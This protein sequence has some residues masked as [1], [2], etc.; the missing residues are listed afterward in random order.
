V[1]LNVLAYGFIKSV[2]AF[3]VAWLI[4]YLLDLDLGS[5]A[6]L[7]TI[8]WSASVF[9][10]G[11]ASAVFNRNYDKAV[12]VLQLIV[13]FFCFIFLE[14]FHSKIYET[15]IVMLIITCGFFYGGPY[16]LMSTAIPILLG[17]QPAVQQYANGKG[18]IIALMEGYGQLFCGISLLLVPLFKVANLNAAGAA[19][20]LAALLLLAA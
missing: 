10:G 2:N 5:E 20:C 3:I 13:S 9:A 18:M 16:N 17:S 4:Y 8:L 7:M 11:M 6:V 14:E 19:Y 15:R 12:F 1:A